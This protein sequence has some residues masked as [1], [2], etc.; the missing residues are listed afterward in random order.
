[1]NRASRA[2]SA[3]LFLHLRGFRGAFGPLDV[4][5]SVLGSFSGD[6]FNE[7]FTFFV[8][9][10]GVVAVACGGVQSFLAKT[11]ETS[12]CLQTAA[13]NSRTWFVRRIW[14]TSTAFVGTVWKVPTM[15][16]PVL[17]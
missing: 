8:I 11:L 9:Y 1:M 15:I 4:C 10:E 6:I 3:E 7:I 14:C 5:F 13:L 16:F 2:T 12:S 17:W